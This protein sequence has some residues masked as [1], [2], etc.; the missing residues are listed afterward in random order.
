MELSDCVMT[1][2]ESGKEAI[3]VVFMEASQP[4]LD[5]W[6]ASHGMELFPIPTSP[7]DLPT[8]GI[9]PKHLRS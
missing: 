9:S 1:R 4:E 5:R 3:Q 6:L 8:F 7:D 2:Y